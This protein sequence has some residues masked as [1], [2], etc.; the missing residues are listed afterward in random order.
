MCDCVVISLRLRVLDT[1]HWTLMTS[2]SA[3]APAET[4]LN[5]T[6]RALC[7]GFEEGGLAEGCLGPP[8]QRPELPRLRRTRLVHVC[9]CRAAAAAAGRFNLVCRNCRYSLEHAIQ[10]N[11]F[12]TAPSR[13]TITCMRHSRSSLVHAGRR[14]ARGLRI[15]V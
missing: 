14:H 2:R 13:S 5:I 12:V 11:I 7:A 6:V 10:V 3:A 9:V 15:W 1:I 4:C 8:T